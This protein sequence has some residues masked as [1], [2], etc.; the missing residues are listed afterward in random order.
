MI[1][2]QSTS[3]KIILVLSVGSCPPPPRP[4]AAATDAWTGPF[5]V[6]N[7]NG[8]Q[9]E[10]EEDDDR[11]SKKEKSDKKNKTDKKNKSDAKK[12]KRN[13]SSVVEVETGEED[14]KKNVIGGTSVVNIR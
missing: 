4:V 10:D 5:N 9:K 8:E 12:D 2:P 1:H 3:S 14:R 13:K 11:T 6:Y 7:L